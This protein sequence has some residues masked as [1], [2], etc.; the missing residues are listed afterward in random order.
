MVD[1]ANLLSV[2]RN[3]NGTMIGIII[4]LTVGIFIGYHV[5]YQVADK[6]HKEEWLRL[7][8]L[9]IKYRRKVRHENENP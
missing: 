8:R 4:S 1:Y 2:K 5:G 9:L 3:V 6:Q 7:Q